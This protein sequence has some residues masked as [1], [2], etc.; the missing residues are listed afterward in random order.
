MLLMNNL[1]NILPFKLVIVLVLILFYVYVITTNEIYNT[2]YLGDETSIIGI[3]KQINLE[4]NKISLVIDSE[5]KVLV[6][7]YLNNKK[8]PNLK[9]GYLIKVEGVLKKPNKNTN[10]NLFNYRNYLLSQKIYW[11]FQADSYEI[12]DTEVNIYYQFKNALY[13]RIENINQSKTYIKTLVLGD[14]NIDDEIMESYRFNGIS[15]LLAVS[16]MHVTLISLLILAILKIFSKNDKFNYLIVIFIIVIY[17]FL[18]DLKPPIIRAGLLFILLTFNKIFKFKIKT[19]TYLCLIFAF[20][21]LINPYYIYDLGF[22]FSFVVTFYLILFKDLYIKQNYF[23][24]TLI[25][26]WIAFLVS[27]PIMINNFFEVNLLTPLLNVI[28][29]PLVSV[30]IFPLALF[31]ILF[32]SLDNILYFLIIILE[33]LSLFCFKIDYFSLVLGKVSYLILIFYYLIITLYLFNYHTKKYLIILIVTIILH[34]KL[35]YFNFNYELTFLD[36]GQGDSLLVKLPHD[37]LNVLIDTG[38][39]VS[40]NN[41]LFIAKNTIIPYL[42]SLGIKRIDYL[43]LTHGDY[44]HI[45]EAS[46][47]IQNFKV[48]NVIFN[49]DSFNELE[50]ELIKTLEKKNV[51]Y[52][53]NMSELNINNNKLYFLN[54]K[55]YDNENDNSNVIYTELN[56]YKFLFMGDASVKVEEDI[57]TKYELKNIDVLK[58]GHHGSKTSSSE[59][60]IDNINPKYS[61]ISVGKNNMYNHPNDEVLDTLSN[62]KKF[63]IDQNGSIKITI[64]NNK[65]KIDTCTL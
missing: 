64:K 43:I 19:L 46:Y 31:T 8:I 32:P 60:F 16:G 35:S 49:N 2:K 41:S 11:I 56:N 36:V 52:Y 38:G 59:K 9:R 48:E 28:F 47:L 13:K 45:G 34:S 1:K 7:Y 10:F 3:I 65:F 54:D 30:I 50:L 53:Q 14:N 15:H 20:L 5:E 42:K 21:L 51:L 25:V 4:D 37:Q 22:K 6:N 61:I 17:M 44:D 39:V 63:R 55:L 58:V 27:I 26:S 12:I 24:K 33:K 23:F 29:V 18:T 40:D 62:L 57:I